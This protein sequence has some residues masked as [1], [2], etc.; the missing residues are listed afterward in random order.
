[1]VKPPEPHKKI[2]EALE[3]LPLVT[4]LDQ[5]HWVND[6]SISLVWG[7]LR[8]RRDPGPAP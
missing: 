7:S 3:D 1:M 2:R 5:Y 8:G 6:T 4:M